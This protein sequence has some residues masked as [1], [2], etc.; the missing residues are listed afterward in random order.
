MNTAS[1]AGHMGS[2]FRVYRQHCSAKEEIGAREMA[3]YRW[4]RACKGVLAVRERGLE[5]TCMIG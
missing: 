4:I 1:S 5:C 3:V 2:K